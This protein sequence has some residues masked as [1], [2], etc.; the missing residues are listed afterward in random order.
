M[1]DWWEQLEARLERELANF[2]AANPAQQ[3]L[4]QE[5]EA[6]DR[7]ASLVGERG[8][9]QRQAE[10][11]RQQ[12]LTLAGEIR[13]WRQRVQRARAA[14]AEPLAE[15]AEAHLAT[16]M[17]RG[18]ESWCQLAELGQQFAAVEAALQ[19]LA[20]AEQSTAAKAAPGGKLDELEQ[21]WAVFEAEQQL[22]SLRRRQS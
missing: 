9:L 10:Q 11:Q 3:A 12:L 7:Q 22:E 6:R 16:L 20:V 19:A 5:Q 15:R 2:L 13:S 1:N 8:R 17:E 18:R 21:A 4:L 14:G